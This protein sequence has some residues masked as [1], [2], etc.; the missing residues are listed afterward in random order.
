MVKGWLHTYLERVRDPII[1][2]RSLDLMAAAFWFCL[3][4]WGMSSAIVGLPTVYNSLGEL[5]LMAW[6]AAIGILCAVAFYGA[7][8]TFFSNPII[9]LRIKRKKVEMITAGVAGGFIAVYPGLLLVSVIFG[10][11]DRFSTFFASLA[12]LAV[13]T[14]R[15]RHL[16]L[17]IA[18]LREI[19]N[20]IATHPT[21]T[22]E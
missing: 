9:N 3:S 10:D 12:Y 13:P 8:S 22:I 19:R 21:Q 7:I 6:G 17:R 4:A 20:T 1:A 11:W 16:Y 14:W 2:D 15:V 18:K 5:Y